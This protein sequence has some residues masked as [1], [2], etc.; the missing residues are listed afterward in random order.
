[1]KLHIACL[2]TI[3]LNSSAAL[4]IEAPPLKDP[5][6]VVIVRSSDP[7]CE[8]KCAEWISAEGQFAP[9]VE[10]VFASALRAMGNR[11]LPI[12]L[13]SPGG[14]VDVA[15]R[16][17]RL[18]RDRQLD[19]V[20]TKTVFEGCGPK[21]K[22]CATPI[23]PSGYRGRP[24]TEGAFCASACVFALAGG[25]HRYVGYVSIV[26]VHQ[27]IA[28]RTQTFARYTISKRRLPNGQII[29]TKTTIGQKTSSSVTV[30]TLP[31]EYKS[32]GDYLRQMGIADALMPLMF[33]TPASSLRQLDARELAATHLATARIDGEALVT[34]I[35]RGPTI[36]A[37]DNLMDASRA[38]MLVGSPDDPQKPVVYLGS[39]VWSTIPPAPGQPVT[40]AVKAD[41]DIPDLKMHATMILRKNT[42][43]TLEA[44]HTIDLP[45]ARRS[46]ASRMSACR[47]CASSMRP[48]RSS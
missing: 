17:G 4:A 34:T 48:R 5:M 20:V 40:V 2:L 37:H 33:N 13:N 36:S 47:R 46:P 43:P 6:T 41:A 8:P 28:A 32:Y 29:T 27:V 10:G 26:G 22:N 15:I 44:T 45:R 9:G 11:R 16:V 42:D 30:E 25:V 24:F 21:D 39:T 18:I 7:H 19:V 23:D 1:M 3:F 12:F 35:E 38:A 14:R 31:S